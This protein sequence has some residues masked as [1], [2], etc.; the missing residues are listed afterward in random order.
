MKDTQIQRVR[1]FNRL[2]TR[3]IGVLTDDYLGGG[4]PWSE[5]RLMFEIGREG[6]TVR[7]LR[8]RLSLDSGYLSR[9]LRSLEAQGLVSSRPAT[10]DARVRRL[11]LT[12]KGLREW[13]A[14]ES[15]SD[16]IASTLLAPLSPSQRERLLAAMAEVE[17]LLLAG[18]VTIS[19]ADPAGAQ[20]QACI[21]AYLDELQTRFAGGFDPTLGPQVD[22]RRLVPPEGLFL[23]ATLEGEAVG[24]AALKRLSKGIGEVKRMWVAPSVRGMGIARRMLEAL[25]AHAIDMGMRTLRL[26]TGGSQ[27][28]AVALYRSS[29]YR[30]IAPYNDNPYAAHWFEKR[31]IA[32]PAAA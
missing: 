29:G 20:A 23:L 1:R 7:D 4:R 18:A 9:L 10:E 16:G 12:R 17:R 24:C 5:S 22:P 31:R 8:E 21:G 6:A 2:V 14:M 30:E 32:K 19:P 13:Q 25:E 28:E 11:A 26:D 3:R 15:R 27:P